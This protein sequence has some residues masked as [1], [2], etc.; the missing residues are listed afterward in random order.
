VPVLSPTY[1]AC[2]ADFVGVFWECKQIQKEWFTCSHH[3]WWYHV[4]DANE[5]V[6]IPLCKEALDYCCS[7]TIVR[8]NEFV[9]FQKVTLFSHDGP[10]VNMKSQMTLFLSSKQKRDNATVSY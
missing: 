5:L 1:G 2:G 9:S 4:Y 6:S 8:K 7:T 3:S 10:N